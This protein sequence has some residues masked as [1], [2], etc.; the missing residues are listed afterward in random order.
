MNG[1]TKWIAVIGIC[2]SIFLAGA[3]YVHSIDRE[4]TTGKTERE[5]LKKEVCKAE[6]ERDELRK[7]VTE[8][9]LDTNQRLT[10]IETMLTMWA[11]K[12]GI[13]PK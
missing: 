9:T 11:K 3:H 2:V 8:T 4:V 13:I 7:T 12:E 5:T 1:K 10:R 6:V